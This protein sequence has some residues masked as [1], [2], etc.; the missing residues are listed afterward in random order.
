MATEH[1]TT[2]LVLGTPKTV[3]RK[4]DSPDLLQSH[5][6]KHVATERVDY[7]SATRLCFSFD[8]LGGDKEKRMR[9]GCDFD[10]GYS[11]DEVIVKLTSVA[12]GLKRLQARVKGEEK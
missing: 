1:A 7:D 11:P 10:D 4:T 9:V 2:N 12:E 5:T 6:L 8:H 3:L